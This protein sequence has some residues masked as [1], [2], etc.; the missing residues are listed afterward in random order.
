V[1]DDLVRRINDQRF[2]PV[3]LREGY[4]MGEVDQF[5]DRLV[6]GLEHA[7]PLAPLV[8]SARFTPVRL[9]EGY[10]MGEVDRFLDEVVAAQQAAGSTGVPVPPAPPRE[11]PVAADRPASGH[12]SVIEEKPGLWAR[13]FGRNR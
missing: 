12:P 5:L 9:R 1:S 7:Q 13:V 6:A 3:R 2:T 10:D 4:D 8:E 11:P